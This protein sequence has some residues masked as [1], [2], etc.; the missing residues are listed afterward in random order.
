MAAARVAAALW[1]RDTAAVLGM[2]VFGTA[3]SILDKTSWVVGGGGVVRVARV[4]ERAL[5]ARESRRRGGA[6]SPAH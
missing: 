3:S 6:A 5:R 4:R 2:L 1:R